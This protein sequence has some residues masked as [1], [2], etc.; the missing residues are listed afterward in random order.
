MKPN[1]QD[2]DN[3]WRHRFFPENGSSVLPFGDPV[4]GDIVRSSPKFSRVDFS[5]FINSMDDT[6]FAYMSLV[7]EYASRP[8]QGKALEYENFYRAM[9]FQRA[10]DEKSLCVSVIEF[11]DDGLKSRTFDSYD[12]FKIYIDEDPPKHGVR[13]LIILEDLPVRCVCLLGSRLRI[14]PCIFARQYSTEDH[15][16]ISEDITAF[17]SIV[18]TSTQD[19]LDYTSDDESLHEPSK[20][21]SFMLRYPITMP[22]LSRKQHPDPRICP[23]WYKPS[24]RY[25]DQSARP[26]FIVERNIETSTRHSH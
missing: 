24:E 1:R 4:D 5:A 17:P 2:Q 23:P 15:S 18:Q 3:P 20:R 6:S 7:R 8:L 9:V 12:A 16:V 11:E 21:R 25:K 13:R 26:N 14:H 22:A 19:G 10:E